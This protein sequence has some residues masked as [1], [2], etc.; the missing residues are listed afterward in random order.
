MSCLVSPWRVTA[1]AVAAPR[2]L[3]GE[4]VRLSV[5]TPTSTIEGTVM[6]QT[7]DSIIIR[8]ADRPRA[9]TTLAFLDLRRIEAA[10]RERSV[11]GSVAG[12]VAGFGAGLWLGVA[13]S[14]RAEAHCRQQ[15]GNHDLCALDPVTVPVYSIGGAVV[16]LVGGMFPRFHRW[17]TVWTR[18]P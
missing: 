15:P 6:R 9:D 12:A 7:A 3:E 5:Q 2:P 18:E 8:L 4:R 10:F 1:Q 11:W 14:R 16:G 17:E 13:A